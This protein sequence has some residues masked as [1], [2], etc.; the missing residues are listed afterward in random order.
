M[1]A[2][3][4]WEQV[5][6]TWIVSGIAT[7]R[8]KMRAWQEPPT[9]TLHAIWKHLASGQPRDGFTYDEQL[10]AFRIKRDTLRLLLN[11]TWR[12]LKDRTDE[13]GKA[14]YARF[15]CAMGIFYRGKAFF[16]ATTKIVDRRW[17]T[18]WQQGFLRWEHLEL[19]AAL[20]DDLQARFGITTSGGIAY[21]GAVFSGF[22]DHKTIYVGVT[23]DEDVV[24]LLQHSAREDTRGRYDGG[25]LVFSRIDRARWLG[26]ERNAGFISQL[27]LGANARLPLELEVLWPTMNCILSPDVQTFRARVKGALLG[28]YRMRWTVD[29]YSEVSEQFTNEMTDSDN[30]EHKQTAPV[31]VS[32]WHWKCKGR[33][34]IRFIACDRTWPCGGWSLAKTIPV[35]I[36]HPNFNTPIVL[37]DYDL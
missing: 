4:C 18:G 15:L 27:L 30:G 21:R 7:R 17:F 28:A 12:C 26:G 1:T 9:D 10:K 20:R 35:F 11:P 13:D 31:D 24:L 5:I 14:A 6:I 25:P 2:R 22:V 34:R 19:P 8:D 23:K 3:E 29:K 16:E 32:Q 37:A 33:Y 36:D